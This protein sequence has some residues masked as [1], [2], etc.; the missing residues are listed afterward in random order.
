MQNNFLE[1][2]NTLNFLCNLDRLKQSYLGQIKAQNN[3]SNIFLNSF[4]GAQNFSNPAPM[5]PKTHI[6]AKQQDL[7]MHLYNAYYS[8]MQTELVKN[9]LLRLPSLQVAKARNANEIWSKQGTV[10]EEVQEYN[11]PVVLSHPVYVPETTLESN[12]KNIVN[13]FVESFGRANQAEIERERLKYEHNDQLRQVFDVLVAKYSAT[14]KTKEEMIKYVFRKALRAIREK[15]REATKKSEKGV[16]KIFCQKYFGASKEELLQKGANLE[17]E[18]EILDILLPFKKTSKNKTLNANFFSKIFASEEFCKEYTEY[19][20]DFEKEADL[21]NAGK[22]KRFI[23][24]IINCIKTKK[25]Q[26]IIHYKRAPW[27]NIWLRN[28]KNVGLQLLKENCEASLKKKTKLESDV[29]SGIYTPDLEYKIEAVS[30]SES[31]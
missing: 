21:D 2:L 25:T 5:L 29:V 26:S 3:N 1:N 13:F 17:D 15:I 24:Y 12:V 6:L 4:I 16:N 7:N 30:T 19:L 8:K 10:K 31:S 20:A 9:Q 28:T 22:I 14:A 23:S 27:L 18:D 11:S